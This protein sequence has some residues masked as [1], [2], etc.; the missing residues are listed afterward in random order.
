MQYYSYWYLCQATETND[1][2]NYFEIVKNAFVGKVVSYI[3]SSLVFHLLV[4]ID[5]LIFVFFHACPVCF[6]KSP[7]FQESLISMPLMRLSSTKEHQQ[8]YEIFDQTPLIRVRSFLLL[9]C[10]ELNSTNFHQMA[11]SAYKAHT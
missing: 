3:V 9:F 4:L 8:V 2:Q 5:F 6:I 1:A 7:A 11:F 10:L